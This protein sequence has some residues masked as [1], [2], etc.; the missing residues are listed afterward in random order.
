M[1]TKI[2]I[3]NA[4]KQRN[5]EMN[6]LLQRIKYE[7]DKIQHEA[8]CVFF[9]ITIFEDGQLI[10]QEKGDNQL[11]L[12]E[13]KDM[14]VI[15]LEERSNEER[16]ET[17]KETEMKGLIAEYA[18]IEPIEPKFSQFCSKYEKLTSEV[19]SST[20]LDTSFDAPY[21]IARNYAGD[22]FYDGKKIAMNRASLHYQ[23][24]NILYSH[25]D[26]DGFLSYE[27]IEKHL[28]KDYNCLESGDEDTRNKRI[29]NA[30]LNKQ[31]GL[32]RVAKVNGH[33]L[34][35]TIPD[36]RKLIEPIRGQGLK[37]N[38]PKI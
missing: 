17:L 24:F 29:N 11:Y 15:K 14:G 25:S 3:F 38:N 21:L 16:N 30:T 5:I 32:F 18:L 27:D 2:E 28:V 7:S 9:P 1:D 33:R 10:F 12:K 22:Y 23:V 4:N 36:K 6:N 31:Q 37:L 19:I 26:Q 8:K 34:T 13:L 35:N 20:I